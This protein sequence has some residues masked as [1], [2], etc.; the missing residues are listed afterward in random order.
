MN[1][2]YYY[3][4]RQMQSDTTTIVVPFK[5]LYQVYLILPSLKW[6]YVHRKNETNK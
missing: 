4:W 3:E 1:S 2:E 6:A 5:R